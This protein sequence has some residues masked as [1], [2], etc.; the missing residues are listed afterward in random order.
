MARDTSWTSVAAFAIA[1]LLLAAPGVA[2]LELIHPTGGEYLSGDVTIEWSDTSSSDS[3]YQLKLS[4]S[5]TE[6]EPALCEACQGFTF[7]FDTG[8]YADG[9]EYVLTIEED[10]GSDGPSAGDEE[11][12]TSGTFTI[13]NTVPDTSANLEGHLGDDGWYTEP[14]TVTLDGDDETAGVDETTYSLDGA[15]QQVYDGSFEVAGEGTHTVD[16]SSVDRAGNA[17]AAERAAFRIDTVDPTSDLTVSQPTADSGRVDYVSGDTEITLSASDTTSGVD[18]I[19]YRINDG[20]FQTYD[21][22]FTLEGEDGEYVVEWRAVDE[23]RNVETIQKRRFELDQTA[24]LLTRDRPQP[25]GLYVDDTLVGETHPATAEAGPL[26]VQQTSTQAHTVD[27]AT[28]SGNLTVDADTTDADAGGDEV[29]FYVDGQLRAT[30]EE[31]PFEWTWDTRGETLGEHT[32]TI[33]S[34][35]RLT[36]VTSTSIDVEVVPAGPSGLQSTVEDGPSVPD[37]VP[38]PELGAA[39]PLMP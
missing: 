34:E 11:V 4:A 1:G 5:G 14:V 10:A 30:V 27:F 3:V 36:H 12:T 38:S 29:R 9:S 16:F 23:A 19:E 18:H 7:T 28:A 32:L 22:P 8:A 33:E 13:D 20:S 2:A 31:R 37:E 39:G 21:G 26:A 15:A 24:P 25:G 17:E 35:D 6:L